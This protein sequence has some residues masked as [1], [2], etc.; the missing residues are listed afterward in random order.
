MIRRA[1]TLCTFAL[2]A[3]LMA[4][5]AAAPAHAEY[6]ASDKNSKDPN[7]ELYLSLAAELK[8]I[9]DMFGCEFAWG[10]MNDPSS[11]QLEFAPRGHDVRKWTRLVTI[12]TVLM[13]KESAQQHDLVQRLQSIMMDNF[14]QHG[15]VI[16]TKS[17]TDAKGL[18]T[19]YVEY[20]T[21]TG[22]AKE[23]NAAAIMRLRD[24]FAGIVQIQS[25][26]KPLAREDATK[27]QSLALPK[28][29]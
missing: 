7:R 2:A 23:H 3:A 24:E 27:M 14:K 17:G 10:N 9:P 19:L 20:E 16:E 6:Y 13:S 1:L 28:K 15:R 8:A 4:S 11:V 26:G 29:N 18:P 22:A 21:G 5:L 25:R 12:T